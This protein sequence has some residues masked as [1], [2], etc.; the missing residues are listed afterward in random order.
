[1]RTQTP[2]ATYDEVLAFKNA[3]NAAPEA[4]KKPKKNVF[5]RLL[6]LL[7]AIA[8][9][10]L[11]L[12]QELKV[13]TCSAGFALENYKL[14]DLVTK[15]FTEDGFATSK[16]FGVLPLLVPNTSVLGLA[17]SLMLYLIPVS[18]ALC[19]LTALVALF[20]G[21]AAPGCVRFIAFVEFGVY[22]G[23]AI[24][25]I[26]PYMFYGMDYMA[27]LDYFVLGIAGGALLFYF[28]MSL[29]KSGGRAFFG[30]LVFLLTLASAGVIIYAIATQKDSMLLLFAEDKLYKWITVGVAG[31]YALFVIFALMGVSA[32]R[33]YGAD[34]L[35]CV[36]MLLLGG[37][38]I[39][40]SFVKEDIFKDFQIYGIIAA[41]AAL[42]M[43]I[44]ESI[45]LGA[46]KKKLAKEAAAAAAEEAERAAKLAA[47]LAQ[48][49]STEP[50]IDYDALNAAYGDAYDA[51]VETLT[52]EEKVEFMNVF[53]NRT[54]AAMPQI[55]AY[56]VGGDNAAFFRKIFVHLS[57]V[58]DN[59]PDGLMY[60]IYKYTAQL[61]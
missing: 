60:K 21:K 56:Q 20:S 54:T 36:I 22:A 10:V 52:V 50:S 34:I 32:K 8:P 3:N 28:I 59:V 51:F 18:M 39:A 61:N 12:T 9:I 26:L 6:A 14:L 46:R 7:L 13:L 2:N 37:G 11:F 48:A 19:V 4:V 38:I 25:L 49:N 41:G 27:T 15:L 1:M 43:L 29:A 40:L 44:F 16:L 45:A 35:R 47:L 23:Y 31:L 53:L 17:A 42:L 55:P 58:R 33:V 5:C 30:F 24:S 57:A